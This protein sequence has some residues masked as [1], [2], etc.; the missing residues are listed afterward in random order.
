M[1]NDDMKFRIVYDGPALDSHEMDVRD[2][3]PALLSLSDALEEAGKTIYGKEKRISVKVNASFKAGSFGV[4]LIAQSS[5]LTAQ[6]IG[7]FSGNTASAASNIIGLVG[8]GYLVVN[9]SCKGLIQLIKWIGPRQIKR[10]EPT[11]DGNSKIFVD[12]NYEVFDSQVVELYKNKK[13]RKS[14]ENVIY[15]PLEREGI[16]SFAVTLDQGKTFVEVVKEEAIF[17]K[18]NGVSEKILSESTTE[19]ALQ[20][21]DISFLE[22]HKWRFSDGGQPF[23][24]DVSDERFLKAIDDQS[25]TFAKGDLLLVDLKTTQYVADKGIKTVYEIVLVKKIIN[26]FRQIDLPF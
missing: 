15:K 25:I 12:D 3:A 8:F 16:D 19:K 2:L 23:Q 21:L 26:P 17:F 5:S 4:D 1:D 7:A 14:L 22:G 6:I 18:V 10:I 9:T 24:A 11:I 13:L 20:P